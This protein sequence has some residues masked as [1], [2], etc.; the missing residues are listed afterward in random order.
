VLLQQQNKTG[1]Y[2]ADRRGVRVQ[3]ITAGQNKPH[4]WQS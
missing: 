4:V 3:N 1:W 2:R